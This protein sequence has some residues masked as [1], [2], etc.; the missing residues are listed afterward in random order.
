MIKKDYKWT[1]VSV[2]VAENSLSGFKNFLNEI[3]L[4]FEIDNDPHGLI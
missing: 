2:S 3:I 4:A 1:V